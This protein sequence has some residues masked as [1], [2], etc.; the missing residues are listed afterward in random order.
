MWIERLHLSSAEAE[1][2]ASSYASKEIAFVRNVCH[3]LQL[4]L[5]GPVCLGVDNK[6]ANNDCAQ[7]WRDG[8]YQA[9]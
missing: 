8:S 7:S 4:G 1:Y 3:E 9:F 6:A 5:H 2:A